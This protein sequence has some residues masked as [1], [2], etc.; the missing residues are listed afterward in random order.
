M[1]SKENLF[2]LPV[3]FLLP[4]K[5]SI[6]LRQRMS[7][8]HTSLPIVSSYLPHNPAL[9]LRLQSEPHPSQFVTMATGHFSAHSTPEAIL[10]GSVEHVMHRNGHSKLNVQRAVY[11]LLSRSPFQ[12]HCHIFLKKATTRMAIKK[13]YEFKWFSGNLM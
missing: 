12:E 2:L 3:S 1:T 5:R 13:I 6:S 4:Y 10:S 9:L 11:H 7:W 8:A